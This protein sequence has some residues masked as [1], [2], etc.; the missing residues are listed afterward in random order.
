MREGCTNGFKL[1]TPQRFFDDVDLL[2]GSLFLCWAK[3]IRGVHFFD[4]LSTPQVLFEFLKKSVIKDWQNKNS[5]TIFCLATLLITSVS[6]I[7]KEREKEELGM[8]KPAKTSGL[9]KFLA[10]QAAGSK[11]GRKLISNYTGDNGNNILDSIKDVSTFVDDKATAK[12]NKEVL[13]SEP[14]VTFFRLLIY[15]EKLVRIYKACTP[16]T[17]QRLLSTQ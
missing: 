2:E 16:V 3:A 12:K 1:F 8:S 10:H 17:I 7:E 15:I 11:A 5:C 14:F 4:N 9:K 13:Q 6:V